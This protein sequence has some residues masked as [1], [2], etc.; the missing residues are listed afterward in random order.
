MAT[1]TVSKPN[2]T[3]KPGETV[4][5]NT[6]DAPIIPP[7]EQPSSPPSAEQQQPAQ[8]PTDNVQSALAGQ[9]PSSPPTDVQIA[10]AQTSIFDEVILRDKDT[11]A[12]VTN[13]AV[14]N[15]LDLHR[16]FGLERA[17]LR[18]SEWKGAWSRMVGTFGRRFEVARGRTAPTD[19]WNR[20]AGVVLAARAHDKANGFLPTDNEPAGAME[21]ILLATDLDTLVALSKWLTWSDERV[22]WS[23]TDGCANDLHALIRRVGSDHLTSVQVK[24][25]MESVNRQRELKRIAALDGK[26]RAEAEAA[27]KRVLR[28]G[29][30]KRLTKAIE[31]FERALTTIGKTTGRG[32]SPR[33]LHRE[34]IRAGLLEKMEQPTEQQQPA[35][36]EQPTEQPAK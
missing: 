14:Q 2:R 8:Q 17:H 36:A 1:A 33:E 24:D 7:T 25:A 32:I 31:T 6:I 28:A 34:L 12:S 21:S 27:A 35:S 5:D 15:G 20:G 16:A 29:R 26:A 3:R 9:Q 22:A 11:Q 19:R 4:P 13:A 23:I 10:D 30:A 18:Q